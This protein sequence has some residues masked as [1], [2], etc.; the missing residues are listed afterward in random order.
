MSFNMNSKLIFIDSFQFLSYS[1]DS[2][3]KNL[4]K[5]LSIKVKNLIVSFYI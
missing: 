1:L 5:I 4:G 2:L 3:L